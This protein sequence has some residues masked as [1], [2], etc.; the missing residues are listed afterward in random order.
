MSHRPLHIFQ[1]NSFYI[2]T[3]STY[4]KAKFFNTEKKLSILTKTILDVLD[5]YNWQILA[6]AVFANHYHLIACSTEDSKPLKNTIQRIHSQASRLVNKIDYC[7]GR[8]I[9]YQYWDTCISNEKSY[10]ARMKY[11]IYNPVKHGLVENP[12][13]YPFCSAGWFIENSKKGFYNEIL[14]LPI[15]RLNI[16]DDF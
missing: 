13:D 11:V 10:F 4:Q 15:D 9:W 5:E 3:A 7:P 12:L 16:V 2:I 8:R 6:W 1:H 14:S